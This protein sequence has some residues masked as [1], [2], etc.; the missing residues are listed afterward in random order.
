MKRRA[1][2][3]M[4]G[5][6]L[7]HLRPKAIVASLAVV[8]GSLASAQSNE[9]V[10]KKE[11]PGISMAA[12][13]FTQ[14]CIGNRDDISKLIELLPSEGFAWS[15]DIKRFVHP[16]HDLSFALLQSEIG[17]ACTMQ[18]A[19]HVD[20]ATSAAIFVKKTAS[21]Q[22]TVNVGF[23]DDTSDRNYVQASVAAEANLTQ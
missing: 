21:R 4:L 2:I 14:F 23:P 8:V 22:V 10:S 11:I 17:F 20:A 16:T 1:I 3:A 19:N 6:K 15:P 9:T 18:F 7:V 12:D 5:S 13:L